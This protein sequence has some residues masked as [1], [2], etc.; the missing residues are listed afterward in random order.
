MALHPVLSRAF[1]AAALLAAA[2]CA[3][4]P[5]APPVSVPEVVSA[6][7]QKVP[8]RWALAVAPHQLD[9][10]VEAPELACGGMTFAVALDGA[11]QRYLIEGFRQIADDVTPVDHVLSPDEVRAGGYSGQILVAA[12]AVAPNVSFAQDGLTSHV[13][14]NLMLSATI[15]VS[16]RNRPLL[17]HAFTASGISNVDAGIV[18]QN[19]QGGIGRAAASALQQIA[20][21]A[22]GAFADS[23][24]IRLVVASR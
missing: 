9:S 24:D 5:D 2:A 21:D 3:S 8:G 13:H 10:T 14:S 6:Y 22:A 7:T 19:G 20:V 15:D 11:M 17:H 4:V 12:S 23:A 16:G 1:S 18:C